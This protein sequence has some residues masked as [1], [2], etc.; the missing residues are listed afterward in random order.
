MKLYL[1][2]LLCLITLA[3][4]SNYRESQAKADRKTEEQSHVSV[5]SDAELKLI[6][7]STVLKQAKFD[8]DHYCKYWANPLDFEKCKEKEFESAYKIAMITDIPKGADTWCIDNI[9]TKGYY[10]L[11]LCLQEKVIDKKAWKNLTKE[12]KERDGTDVWG[13]PL[14]K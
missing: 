9:K 4:W 8:V 11:F 3:F 1:S 6:E 10:S 12:I 5:V 13:G 14:K 2:I 7:N